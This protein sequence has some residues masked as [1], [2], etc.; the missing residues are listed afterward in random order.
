MIWYLKNTCLSP[1]AGGTFG[2]PLAP[3]MG[4][5]PDALCACFGCGGITT[6]DASDH[7]V[8]LPGT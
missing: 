8:F 3:Y 4:Y 5:P 1:L 6:L 2:Y 7:G